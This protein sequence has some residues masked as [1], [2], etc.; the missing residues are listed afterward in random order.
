[1]QKRILNFLI[2]FIALVFLGISVNYVFAQSSGTRYF[3][4]TGHWANDEFLE[5]YESSSDPTL[6]LG[7]P[8]TEAYIDEINGPTAGLLIQYFHKAR[9]EF[10]P[11][12]PQGKKV[13]LT[14]LG[15]TFVQDKESLDLGEG[16]PACYKAATWSY[17]I[18][19]SFLVFYNL[20]GGEIQFGNPISGLVV[21]GNRVVQYFENTKLEWRPDSPTNLKIN[22]SNLGVSHFHL[23]NGNL[24]RLQPLTNTAVSID[25]ST[26][27]TRGFLGKAVTTLNDNQ[28][29]YVVVRDQNNAPITNAQV[30][31]SIQLPS[32]A[33]T[34]LPTLF[35]NENGIATGNY[36]FNESNIGTAKVKI[37]ITFGKLTK[38]FYTSFRIWY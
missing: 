33:S 37:E 10:H 15:N 16:N 1:M 3:R 22:L 30:K 7:Y 28:S 27:L 34:N 11:N 13:V 20:Y 6:L 5:F 4:E 8:I 32:G 17:S 35:S 12:N 24:A 18:C 36:S 19:Y 9:L 38:T 23:L 2:F 21:E 25:V 29:F 31:I 26:L 14:P